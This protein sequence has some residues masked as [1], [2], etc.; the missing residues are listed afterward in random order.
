[1]FH[2]YINDCLLPSPPC[3]HR[4]VHCLLVS[5]LAR[6][7]KPVVLGRRCNLHPLGDNDVLSCVLL[8]WVLQLTLHLRV[9]VCAST[10][11]R[12]FSARPKSLVYRAQTKRPC[13]SVPSIWSTQSA[14]SYKSVISAGTA[15]SWRRAESWDAWNQKGNARSLH[16]TAKCI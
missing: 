9:C 12:V 11:Y 15:L 10:Y 7:T 16:L 8:H 1:M 3:R 14:R 2:P 4:R 13:S 6:S 5:P